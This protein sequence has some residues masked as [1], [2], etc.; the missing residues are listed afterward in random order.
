[1]AGRYFASDLVNFESGEIFAEAGDEIT[2][3]TLKLLAEI[4]ID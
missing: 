3:K 1:M 2:A 4:G